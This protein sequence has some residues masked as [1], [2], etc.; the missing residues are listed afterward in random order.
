MLLSF[1]IKYLIGIMVKMF[2]SGLGDLSSIPGQVIPNASLLN[3]QHFKVQIKG[4]W[5]NP[6]KGVVS[7]PTPWCNNY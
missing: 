3:T 1:K 6:G 2:T 4:K 7:S 5:S